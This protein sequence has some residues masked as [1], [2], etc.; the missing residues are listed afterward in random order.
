MKNMGKM[1]RRIRLIA[2][3]VLII[4]A[5]VLQI[6][7]GKFWWI[8]IVGIVFLATSFLAFCPLYVPFKISTDNKSEN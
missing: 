4:A 6:L 8:G 5:V 3:L 1:D 7:T 2:G